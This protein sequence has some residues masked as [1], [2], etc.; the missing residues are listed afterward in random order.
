MEKDN[1]PAERIKALRKSLGLSQ[2]ELARRLKVTVKTIRRY[3]K[4]ESQPTLPMRRKLRRQA[5]KVK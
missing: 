1:W 3:E 2:D 5:L 4:S